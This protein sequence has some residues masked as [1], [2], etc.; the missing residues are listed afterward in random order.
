MSKTSGTLHF[1]FPVHGDVMVG[2]ADGVWVDGGLKITAVIEGGGAERLTVNGRP[3][4]KGTDG[5]FSAEV[6]LDG[7]FNRLEA[8]NPDSGEKQ[9]ITVFV[10]RKA[11]RKYRFT[12]DD[13]ILAFRDLNEHRGDYASIFDNPY[14]KVFRDAHDRY[15][16][17]VHINA[18]Y[19]TD[20]G[21]F[22]LSMMTDRFRE[23]FTAN[24]DWLSFSFHARREHPDLPYRG[25]G[26][27]EVKRDC[28]L[29][30]NE[31]RRIVGEPA[32]RNTT[33]LHWGE[34]TVYGTRALR[35]MGYR[36]LCG[37]LT[38][39][40]GEDYYREVYEN[41]QPIVSHHL[42]REQVA[43]AEHRCFWVDTEEDVV[44]AKLH[45]ILNAGDLTAD[46]V[47][48]FLDD[49][50][51]RPA[52]SGFIQMVIHEQHFYPDYVAYEPD[53]GDRILTM[54]KWMQ[55]HGY[56]SVSLS[57]IIEETEGPAL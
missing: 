23:E 13:F 11:Y 30:T 45:M 28:L 35:A 17:K 41:G 37:Y 42:N 16:S 12:V 36:A 57:D 48:A 24:A 32:L 31:L 34:S 43:H 7:R 56:E 33:T 3:A 25:K 21:A 39:C 54:A 8:V 44:F 29:V 15:G 47:E 1:L 10:F 27:E 18:F 40:R 46:R 55:E 6:L 20:D 38:F 53:Y 2:E 49:L 26:Y 22:N 14:L 19:E 51:T 5:S 9:A 52:E 4:H 50:I